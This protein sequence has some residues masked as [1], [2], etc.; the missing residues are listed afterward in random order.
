MYGTPARYNIRSPF[1]MKWGVHSWYNIWNTIKLYKKPDDPGYVI[2]T[3]R[4]KVK[5]KPMI[6]I[7]ISN[8]TSERY[9]SAAW[10][11]GYEDNSRDATQGDEKKEKR[12]KNQRTHLPISPVS[13]QRW[14][15]VSDSQYW[16]RNDTRA[17]ARKK[18]N[19]SYQF[20]KNRESWMSETRRSP[21]VLTSLQRI[22][23]APWGR[24]KLQL[25]FSLLTSSTSLMTIKQK[26]KNPREESQ[27]MSVPVH[28]YYSNH[29]KAS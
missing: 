7:S 18:Y 15:R 29:N 3:E 17:Y 6:Q 25:R 20:E 10:W 14:S 16:T 26:I 8:L 2:K 1:T 13:L 24:V 28:G 19:V 5:K 22:M 23:L 12:E 9:S 4:N 27:D 11:I 21:S